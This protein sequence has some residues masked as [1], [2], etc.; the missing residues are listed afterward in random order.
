M[1]ARRGVAALALVLAEAVPAAAQDGV[2]L[3]AL[4][5]CIADSGARFYG[6]HWCPYCRKQKEMFGS[7][8]SSLPYVECY[9]GPKSEGMNRRCTRERIDGFPTWE[10]ASG[11]RSGGVKSPRALAAATGCPID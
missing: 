7:H 5:Q 11:E 3:G 10:F 2:D 4:A 1:I 9:D 8:A 6:A